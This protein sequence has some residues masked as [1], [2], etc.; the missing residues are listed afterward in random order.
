MNTSLHG[1][2]ALVCGS[3]QGIGRASAVELASLGASITLMARDPAKLQAVAA[4]LPKSVGQS[5]DFIAADSAN[6]DAVAAAIKPAIDR[7]I[8]I[9]VNNT[10]GPPGGQAI[11]AAPDAYAGAFK[12]HVLSNQ[13]LVQGVVP[14]MKQA[15]YGRIINI[16]STSV[17]APIPNLGVSNTI[18]AAVASW[19]KTL[20]SELAPFG[21]TVNNVLPGFTD[22]SRLAELFK[23]R[24]AK[25]GKPYEIVLQEAIA[26]IPAGRLG[27]PEEI[28]AAVAFLATP[29]AAYVNGIN[30]PVDGGR[31]QSL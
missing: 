29:A 30:V 13:T 15:K 21:I 2:R 3:T 5:H 24:A 18:R 31:T 28:A 6:P 7:P 27:R 20:A 4:E 25:T 1:K 22:T 17:K 10:G 14:G 12:M 11:D 9:L 26:S 19:A 16:I 23:A 8:H